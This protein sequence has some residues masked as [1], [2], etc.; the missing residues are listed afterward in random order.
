MYMYS[1]RHT[2]FSTFLSLF[3][4]QFYGD[5]AQLEAWLEKQGAQ[6]NTYYNRPEV[7]LDEG[8]KLIREI[9][10]TSQVVQSTIR[11]LYHHCL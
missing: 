8:E 3:S 1:V 9:Q 7:S 5:A 10:V 6:L 4:C 11:V 2:V